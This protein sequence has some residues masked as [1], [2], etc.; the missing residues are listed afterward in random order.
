MRPGKRRERVFQ[1]R[2]QLPV[3]LQ[4]GLLVFYGKIQ[5]EYKMHI[6][7]VPRVH[8]APE[9]RKAEQLVR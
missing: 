8:A 5:T 7:F 1:D 2:S 4:K 9:D 6:R 3:P